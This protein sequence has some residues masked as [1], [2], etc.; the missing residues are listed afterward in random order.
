MRPKAAQGYLDQT[1]AWAAEHLTEWYGTPPIE[2]SDEQQS[3]SAAIL[4]IFKGDAGQ[5][6]LL[7][8]HMEWAPAL[9]AS[10]RDW[11]APLLDDPY[12]A[13][14]Y[15]AQRA[16]RRL[17]RYTDFD[18]DFLGAADQRKRASQQALEVWRGQGPRS[19]DRAGPHWLI[20]PPARLRE[21]AFRK[22]LEPRDDRRVDLRE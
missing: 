17:P 3:I 20:D 19:L 13:V 5:R 21:A 18:Y 1:L 6:A 9:E 12:T 22:L 2:L 4:W 10:G 7:A 15:I 16:L 8:W 11:L 14:R